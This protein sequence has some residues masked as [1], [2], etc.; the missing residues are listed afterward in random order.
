MIEMRFFGRVKDYACY[1]CSCV[2]GSSY[3]LQLLFMP[4]SFL[5]C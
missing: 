4:A 3:S 2:K 5:A 1:D